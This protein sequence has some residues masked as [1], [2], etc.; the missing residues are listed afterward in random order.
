MLFIPSW[1][2]RVK[3]V[4]TPYLRYASEPFYYTKFAALPKELAVNS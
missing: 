3:A 4:E 2:D 1:D